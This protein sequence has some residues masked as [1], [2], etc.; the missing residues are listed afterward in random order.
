MAWYLLQRFA[1]ARLPDELLQKEAGRVLMEAME[2]IEAGRDSEARWLWCTK[3]LGMSDAGSH[4][5]FGGMYEMFL[6]KLPDLTKLGLEVKSTCSF[7]G[8]PERV[9]TEVKMK[10]FLSVADDGVISQSAI[11]D[12][13]SG[14]KGP[15]NRVLTMEQ[16]DSLDPQIRDND[17]TLQLAVDDHNCNIG[18]YCCKYEREF[19]HAW[20]TRK[21]KL[22][23]IYCERALHIKEKPPMPKDTLI[24][25]G[26]FYELAAVF[27][28]DGGHF[29]CQVII[30][31]EVALYDGRKR[32]MLAPDASIPAGYSPI[33]AWYLKPL[34]DES[35][36][37]DL[38]DQPGSEG[39]LEERG[40][41][42]DD[43]NESVDEN[44]G[45][46]SREQNSNGS[47]VEPD[48]PLDSN[49]EGHDSEN[50]S[51]DSDNESQD[52]D[53]ESPDSNG[54]RQ[55]SD[56]EEEHDPPYRQM[57]VS[58]NEEHD[59]K[60]R[61]DSDNDSRSS[62]DSWYEWGKNHYGPYGP[63]NCL[64]DSWYDSESSQGSDSDERHSKKKK[65]PSPNDEASRP[66]SSDSQLRDIESFSD[67]DFSDDDDEE[68][69]MEC[70]SD[71][72]IRERAHSPDNRD[73]KSG[74]PL[75][76]QEED[77]SSFKRKRKAS[78]DSGEDVESSN[79]R[80]SRL[81][82]QQGP[83]PA[84]LP[85]RICEGC[86]FSI[87]RKADHFVYQQL[88]S[89]KMARTYFYHFDEKC[90]NRSNIMKRKKSAMF[91]M[92]MNEP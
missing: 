71:D 16:A 37:S 53:N 87:N 86:T 45:Y 55:D 49:T 38:I 75:Y 41:G 47:G 9:A 57:Q 85:E 92:Y 40:S 35:S 76:R 20:I 58:G 81:L 73:K 60:G 1:G 31:D 24:L 69:S 70:S 17:F 6:E 56:D 52:S 15:C 23:V 25:G 44:R 72:Q 48:L 90:V 63:E 42:T 65:I 66:P 29:I 88:I 12:K 78:S 21:P 62:G 4:N 46:N 61:P 91:C 26:I 30:G 54:D 64:Q 80:K 67:D 5:M 3:V 79:P 18:W 19:E 14:K 89:S 51:Q 28:Y 34:V 7:H 8:C 50:E 77:G 68:A 32:P 13:L 2:R 33:M 83:I 39:S 74:S 27:Y 43:E 59:S 10:A 22:L 84:H 82:H 36:A 11:G